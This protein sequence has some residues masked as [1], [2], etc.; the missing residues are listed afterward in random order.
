MTKSELI[1]FLSKQQ[2]HLKA[3]DVDLAVKT[4]LEMMSSSV[5]HAPA[6]IPRPAKR[7]NSAANT[8]RISSRAKNSAT[9]STTLP[10]SSRIL[11]SAGLFG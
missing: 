8:C 5:R 7:S 11:N 3:D 2:P 4:I 6:G 1:E 9:A 10:K